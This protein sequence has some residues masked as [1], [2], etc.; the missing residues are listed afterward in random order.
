MNR[1]R[2]TQHVE[3]NL[4]LIGDLAFTQQFHYLM[5]YYLDLMEKTKASA[6]L[7]WKRYKPKNIFKLSY[8]LFHLLITACL[9][10]IFSLFPFPVK[11]YSTLVYL[12][13][14]VLTV[15][16]INHWQMN[17]KL[18]VHLVLLT[19]WKITFFKLHDEL[20]QYV[21]VWFSLTS[22][23]GTRRQTGFFYFFYFFFF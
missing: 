6:F 5:V 2:H 20:V 18:A 7:A 21:Y 11:A 22:I 10:I 9:V 8:L 14:R 1:L 23:F 19:S 3:P 16:F 15:K 13:I 17:F 12:Y 4:H